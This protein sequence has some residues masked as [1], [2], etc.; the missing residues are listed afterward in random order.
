MF[1]AI[2]LRNAVN[3]IATA[4]AVIRS[5]IVI[6]SVLVPQR[7]NQRCNGLFY[8][9][10]REGRQRCHCVCFVAVLVHPRNLVGVALQPCAHVFGHVFGVEMAV[11]AIAEDGFGAVV[12]GDDDETFVFR[13]VE[14]VEAVDLLGHHQSRRCRSWRS[15]G[16]HSFVFAVFHKITGLVQSLIGRYTLCH[17]RRHHDER[18]HQ[19]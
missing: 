18:E 19:K 9:R 13:H 11:V 16:S 14:H 15:M 3:V 7:G 1:V 17:H 6:R 10:S 2:Y 8:R 5:E 12:V 4:H